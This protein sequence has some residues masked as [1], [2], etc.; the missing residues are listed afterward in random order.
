M[1]FLSCTLVLHILVHQILYWTSFTH[2]RYNLNP[3]NMSLR[4]CCISQAQASDS[5]LGHEYLF[6]GHQY[7]CLLGFCGVLQ[8][9]FIVTVIIFLGFAVNLKCKF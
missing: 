3:G 8:L 4:L 6:P 9:F 7:L 5:Q 1:K 2:S